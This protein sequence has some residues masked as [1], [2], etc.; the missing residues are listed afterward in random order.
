VLILV[1]LLLPPLPLLSAVVPPGYFLP[2][3][4]D[5]LKCENGTFRSEWIMAGDPR[6]SSC[7]TCGTGI[8]SE[9]KEQDDNPM[10]PASSRVASTSASC[11]K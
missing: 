11:C 10:A 9:P 1:L 5:M 6:S 2:T 7:T 4:G 3:N 8:F